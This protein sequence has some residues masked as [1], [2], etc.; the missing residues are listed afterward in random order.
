MNPTEPNHRP[1]GAILWVCS[2]YPSSVSETNGDFI[3]RMARAVHPYAPIVV[4]HAVAD[5]SLRQEEIDRY[6]APF[7]VLIVRYPSAGN[8]LVDHFRLNRAYRRG[9][10]LLQ[11]EGFYFSLLHLHCL[12]PAGRFARFLANALNV[13]LHITEHWT[14]FRSYRS[15]WKQ[16]L[17][18]LMARPVVRRA[19]R[20][21]PVVQA[22][23]EDMR[24]LGLRGNYSIVPNVVD[25]EVFFRK[26]KEVTELRFLHISNLKEVH[27]NVRGLV[28]G[29]QEFRK[30]YPTAV[31]N[32]IGNGPE[33][34]AL[35]EYLT[36]EK[37]DENIR[38]LGP[39]P[40]PEVARH[41][42]EAAIFVL[43]SNRENLPCV[44]LEALATGTPVIAT[45]TGGIHQWVGQ[46]QGVLV[47]PGDETALL[48]A[49]T[50]VAKKLDR[51]E[52]EE[53]AKGVRET[54][55]EEA[56]GQNIASGYE[57]SLRAWKETEGS[58]KLPE[59]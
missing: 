56:I 34:G 23:A 24:A 7:P 4:L 36:S 27:K 20:V 14:G 9:F 31:L 39:Q 50:G 25:I 18:A 21:M 28:R 51:Y 3:E 13:P 49:M 5:P 40:H 59:G 58:P 47:P 26:Q 44:I 38:L 10:D 11:Q 33:E 54:C 32:I 42:R 12:H 22:Q 37:L 6:E 15:G 53:V 35:K 55:S 29:F 2:W 45:E 46:K 43:F 52:I 17:V 41:L 8:S 57:R 48:R 16:R 30:T 19:D 1:D